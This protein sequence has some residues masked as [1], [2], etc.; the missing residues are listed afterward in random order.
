[1][2]DSIYEVT[3]SRQGVVYVTGV[4]TEDDAMVF[5]Q[6]LP[7]SKIIWDDEWEPTDVRE[8]EDE[9]P[10]ALSPTT[11]PFAV[12][13]NDGNGWNVIARATGEEN[14]Q[15]IAEGMRKIEPYKLYRV[16]PAAE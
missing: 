15:R 4:P 12:E 3:I 8:C 11:I 5:A 1:M 2:K 9:T 7:T 16:R 13:E 6:S 10:L 14:A